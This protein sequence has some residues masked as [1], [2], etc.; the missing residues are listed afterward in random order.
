MVNL[1]SV[2]TV[3]QL[4]DIVAFLQRQGLETRAKTGLPMMDCKRALSEA[5][6][7]SL[8]PGDRCTVVR[9]DGSVV[10][11]EVGS[12]SPAASGFRILGAHT[13]SPNLRI[14]PRADV[15]AAIVMPGGADGPAYAVYENYRVILRWNRSDYFATSVG[16]LSD[17][18]AGR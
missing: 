13:D 8:A 2:M 10:A 11:F 1:N 16:I 12:E 6:V 3:Q 18:I 9:N 14:K 17:R 15:S 5:E 7:W 4:A